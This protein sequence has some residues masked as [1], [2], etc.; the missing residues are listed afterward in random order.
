M[1]PCKGQER[2]AIVVPMLFRFDAGVSEGARSNLIKD[3]P[4]TCSRF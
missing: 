3:H 2:V 1:Q 4:A